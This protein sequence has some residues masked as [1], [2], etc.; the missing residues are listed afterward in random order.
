[1]F[2]I[3]LDGCRPKPLASYL[4]AVGILRI[5][6]EQ[7]DP[8]AKGAWRGESFVVNT[9]LSLNEF[10]DFFCNE[11]APTP[12]ISPWNG[13]SGFYAGDAVDG[14]NSILSSE[15]DSFRGHALRPGQVP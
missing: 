4:K 14:I 3:A 8:Q 9:S 12:I 6:S 7:K 13:G 5:L 10:N 1:M 15:H 2:E 11:Y